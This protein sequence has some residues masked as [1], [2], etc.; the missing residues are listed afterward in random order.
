MHMGTS[1]DEAFGVHGGAASRRGFVRA[2]CVSTRRSRS[3]VTT[4]RRTRRNV[5]IRRWPWVA[6]PGLLEGASWRWPVVAA[7]TSSQMRGSTITEGR[8]VG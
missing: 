7:P 3:R 4:R 1:N 2:S 6:A 8:G 5:S